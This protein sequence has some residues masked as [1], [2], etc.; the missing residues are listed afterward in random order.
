MEYE[1][2]PSCCTSSDAQRRH[3][4]HP[5]VGAGANACVLHYRDNDAAV[6]DGDLLLIDA[7]CELDNYARDITRTFPVGGRFTGRSARC[8]RSCSSAAPGDRKDPAGNH[9][10][11]P[12]EAAV[13]AISQGW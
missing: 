8:T 13:R 5:I 1:I 7:G 9:S 6:E 12:H 3:L 2:G 10:N 11:D 4:L